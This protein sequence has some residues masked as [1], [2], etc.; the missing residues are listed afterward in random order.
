MLKF[1]KTIGL[2]L[3]AVFGI[4]TEAQPHYDVID[5]VGTIE[6]RKY[7]PRLAAKVT[8]PSRSEYQARGVAF[9]ILAG[10]IFGKNREKGDIAMTAPVATEKAR[11]INMTAP[12]ETSTDGKSNLTMQ[13]FLPAEITVT[14][15]PTPLDQRVKL[16][17][18]PEQTFASLRFS[19]S[20]S[21]SA[22]ANKNEV[23]LR[24]LKGSKWHAKGAPISLFYD[25][26]FTIPFLRRNEAAIEVSP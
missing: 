24:E 5:H 19:G 9:R 11:T 7:A 3:L 23:L 20:W 1:L 26:P 13:F 4:R 16:V 2:S 18:V 21:P 14:N 8:V 17:E 12:V 6:I 10:Y 15:A 22:L 25:P